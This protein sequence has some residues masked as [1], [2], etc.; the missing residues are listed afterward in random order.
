MMNKR[1]Q[2]V[3]GGCTSTQQTWRVVLDRCKAR[4]VEEV[5]GVYT[6]RELTNRAA[7]AA[8]NVRWSVDRR[9]VHDWQSRR[10][11]LNQEGDLGIAQ[12]ERRR[13]T[14]GG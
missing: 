10:Q 11:T 2:E 3:G 14:A 8:K 5:V 13:C 9:S 7:A 6:G 12:K 4:E 1:K